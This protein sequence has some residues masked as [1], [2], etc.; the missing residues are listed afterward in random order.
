MEKEGNV[1]I[2]ATFVLIVLIGGFFFFN[3]IDSSSSNPIEITKEKSNSQEETDNKIPNNQQAST[4][5]KEFDV[6]A[7]QWDFS[8]NTITVN[9][10]DN[11]ILNIESI[12]VNHGF[13]L[14]TFGISEFLSPGNTV[15]VEFV[16]DKTGTFSFFCNVSCGS[17]HGGM[18]G[19]L[20]VQ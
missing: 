17:G 9:E 19:T 11:V 7:K 6:I 5:T 3:N 20:V 1:F 10:G 16:A 15:K 18:R 2:I 12:D 13:A 8:P 4:E 14:T